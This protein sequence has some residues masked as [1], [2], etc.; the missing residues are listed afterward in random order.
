MSLFVEPHRTSKRPR[1]LV[2]ALSRLHFRASTLLPHQ[3]VL[4]VLV[5]SGP[6]DREGLIRSM[7]TPWVCATWPMCIPFNRQ[8]SA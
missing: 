5:H 8:F 2:A 4:R 7:E 3:T 6:P 1:A